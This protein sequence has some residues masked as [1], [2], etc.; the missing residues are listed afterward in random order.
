MNILVNPEGASHAIDRHLMGCHSD[1]GFSH[2]AQSFSAEMLHGQAFQE[3]PELSPELEETRPPLR[4]W[5]GAGGARLAEGVHPEK[6][7]V[8]DSLVLDVGGSATNRGLGNAGLYL[9]GGREYEGYLVL[10][11]EGPVTLR[12]SLEPTGGGP[13]LAAKELEVRTL[14]G[15]WTKV[16]FSLTPSQNTECEGIDAQSARVADIRCGGAYIRPIDDTT[17]HVCV[18]CG[19]QFSIT[20][21]A[22]GF[23]YVSFASLQPGEWG[24]YKG[25]PVRLDVATAMEEMGVSMLRLGGSFVN[26]GS[27]YRRERPRRRWPDF[28]GPPWLRPSSVQSN[29]GWS[30][31]NG[32]GMFEVID[33][34]NAMGITPLISLNTQVAAHE[35]ADLVEYLWG[36]GSTEFGQ[37]RM[38]DGHPEPYNITWFEIGNEEM[39]KGFAEQVR[40]ME[41]KA[42]EVGMAK[43]FFYIHPDMNN[44]PDEATRSELEG[45][46]LDEWHLLMDVHSN[47]K[48]VEREDPPHVQAA[49]EWK[50]PWANINLET[51]CGYHTVRRMLLEAEDMNK[52]LL[53]R[54]PRYRGR[55]ASF[56][57]ERSGYNE[58]FLN[59]Q[60]L[61]F[62]LPNM[63]WL[64]PPGH[65][66]AMIAKTWLPLAADFAVSGNCSRRLRV[67]DVSAQASADGRRAVVRVLNRADAP[68]DLSVSMGLASSVQYSTIAGPDLQASN[69]PAD[70]EKVVP[71]ALAPVPPTGVLTVPAY[72]YTVFVLDA[73]L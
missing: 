5:R 7:G 64:Q 66:H 39:N 20:L 4:A 10:K 60:G 73:E 30:S 50:K 47:L 19:G 69:T 59:D 70:P 61:A 15:I 16:D 11:A 32:W 18:R 34:C 49:R 62:S 71:S 23:A 8:G 48:F 63:T 65:V 46:G 25:L 41:K 6:R 22:G 14:P 54:D 28:R 9:R 55:A 38:Q 36:N 26:Q 42:E 27:P 56:C 51:N 17:A 29:W 33:F 13:P 40:A 52:Y 58:G 53:R 67:G 43:R 35:L 12:V 37:M 72:S 57:T 3:V 2:Q 68:A 45:L 21:V 24:R 1:A 44:G 31:M